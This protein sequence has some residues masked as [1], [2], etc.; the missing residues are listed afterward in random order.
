MVPFNKR[1]DANPVL[2]PRAEAEFFCPVRKAVVKWE[3]KDVFNPAAVVRGG[4]VYLLYRAEDKVG[5]FAGTS[6]IGCA[7][8]PPTALMRTASPGVTTASRSRR[9]IACRTPSSTP[10]TTSCGAT[11]GRGGARTRAS[12]RTRTAVTG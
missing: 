8:P 9:R 3:E 12:S 6:R 5:K 11:S 2:T 1:A 10:P 4:K 7:P